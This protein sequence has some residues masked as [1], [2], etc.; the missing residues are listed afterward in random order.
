[1]RKFKVGDVV[2]GCI[3]GRA[4]H[5][6]Y[7]ILAYQRDQYIVKIISG[8]NQGAVELFDADSCDSENI[9][10][11]EYLARNKFDYDLKKLLEE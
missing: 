4:C 11:V 2:R 7:K 8:P 6:T 3:D 9:L 5:L 10:D 1:M